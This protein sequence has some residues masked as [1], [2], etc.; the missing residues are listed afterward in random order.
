MTDNLREKLKSE[1][2]QVEWSALR[3]HMNRDVIILVSPEL[4]L[5]DV[6]ERIAVD[7]KTQIAEWIDSGLLS[8]P[9]LAE[10]ETWEKQMDRKFLFLIVSPYVLTQKAAH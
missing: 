3:P 1:L 2:Q 9:T 6:G 4:D 8:K 5:V 7:D 10:L